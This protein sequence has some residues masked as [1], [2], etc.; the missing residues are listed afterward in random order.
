MKTNKL[1]DVVVTLAMGITVVG[2]QIGK[3]LVWIP[4]LHYAYN[5]WFGKGGL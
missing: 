4:L 1:K 2:L 5:Y 3:I